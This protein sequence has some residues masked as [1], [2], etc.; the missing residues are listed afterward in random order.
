MVKDLALSLLWHSGWGFK[1]WP[2]NFCMLWVW[3]KK[4]KKKKK[5]KTLRQSRLGLESKSLFIL[6][7]WQPGSS[8]ST[9]LLGGEHRPGVTACWVCPGQLIT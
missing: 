4:K 1:P 3:P 9:G 8:N 2:G 7:A 5:P 6:T